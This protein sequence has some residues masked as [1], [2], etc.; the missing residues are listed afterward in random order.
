[1][2]E[3]GK[4]FLIISLIFFFLGIFF[5][6][7]SKIPFL[8]K[9]P[10]DIFIQKENFVFFFPLTSCLVVSLIIS[11]FLLFLKIIRR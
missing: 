6:N 5:S 1:M 4:L 11:L 3:I 9:L 8:G 7:F 2:A 10:G